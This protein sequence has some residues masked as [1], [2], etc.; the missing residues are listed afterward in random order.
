MLLAADHS[1]IATTVLD[2]LAFLARLLLLSAAHLRV[3]GGRSL[4]GE[5]VHHALN[6]RRKVVAATDVFTLE[7]ERVRRRNTGL[8]SEV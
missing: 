7:E 2:A 5:H 8:A 4:F 3:P 1:L 6:L